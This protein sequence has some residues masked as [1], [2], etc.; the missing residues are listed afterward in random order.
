MN[1]EILFEGRRYRGETTPPATLED[2]SRYE[3]D[4]AFTNAPL[5][6]RL[7]TKAWYIDFVAATS[8]LVTIGDIG[9]ARTIEFWVNL[10]STT[11]SILEEL[12]ANGI[13]AAAGSMVYANWDN[14]FVNAVDT[15]II[16]AGRWSQIVIT[17]ATPV[18]MSAFRLGL[19]NATYLDGGICNLVVYTYELS[20]GQ[21]IK[22][23]EAARTLF[24][25]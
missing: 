11:E 7:S 3:N 16:T 5:W 15:D 17:S 13:S 21:I 8:Q 1:R 6:T 10:D 24:G 23:S 22:H 12:A 25:V 14:C 2:A 4:G 20:Q 9:K 18:T 19:V